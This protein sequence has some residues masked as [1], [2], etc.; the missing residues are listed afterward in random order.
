MYLLVACED[1]CQYE[2]GTML[3]DRVLAASGPR[4][5]VELME[6]EPT[7]ARTW[8]EIE[9]TKYLELRKVREALRQHGLRPA[10]GHFDGSPGDP[11]AQMARNVFRLARHLNQQ[12]QQI[13]AVLLLWDMDGQAQARRPGLEQ[14]REEARRL[15]FG[16]IAL[17]CPDHECEA[18]ALSAF[19]PGE[20]DEHARLRRERERLEFCPVE[21]SH[22]LKAKAEAEAEAEPRSVKRVL[23]T[24]TRSDPDRQR[25][26]LREATLELLEERGQHNGLADFLREVN[27]K[28]LPLLA[29]GPRMP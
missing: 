15:G 27:E 14:A 13:D 10:Y 28:L 8:V 5:L 26:C 23:E 1:R 3:V 9:N 22:R 24:L 4:W 7:A 6:H 29:P 16:P 17:G 18:W 25:R 2:A 19:E 12:G 21:Q 20:P 11:G